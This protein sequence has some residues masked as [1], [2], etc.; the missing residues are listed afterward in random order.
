M[1]SMLPLARTFST[2]VATAG[3][4]DF[5][6]IVI[7]GGGLVGNAMAAAIGSKPSL[8][9]HKVLLLESGQ[10]KSLGAPPP[11]HSN[12]VFAVGPAA[13]RMFKEF[14]VWPRLVKYRVKEVTDLYVIDSCS[15]S[16][17]RF[18]QLSED[19]EIAYIVENDAIVSGLYDK[20]KDDCANVTVR[21]KAR[22]EKCVLPPSLGDLAT[23]K[24]ADGSEVATSLLIGADGFNSSVRAA[25]AGKYTSWEYNQ[26][27]IVATLEISPHSNNSIAWQ[28]FTPH[29]PIALLPL[30]ESL[31]SL[32]W[33]TTPE[34]GKHLKELAP[35]QFVDELNHYLHTEKQQDPFTNQTLF[36]LDKLGSILPIF[37]S[38]YYERPRLTPP[39]IVGLQTDNRAAFPLGFGHADSYVKSRGVLVGDAAHRM[40]PLAGQGVNLGWSDVRILVDKLDTAAKEGGDV[41]SLAYLADYDSEAQRHNMPVM[42]SVDWLNRL[43]RTDFGPLVFLRSLGLHTFEKLMPLKDLLIYQASK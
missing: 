39:M 14:G 3:K 15:D 41:G 5:Y 36:A 13:I 25:M 4:K 27:G 42:V 7:V 40:H 11:D 12:R 2:S 34:H 28:R 33:T 38:R 21:T 19:Q 32:V 9:S 35:D 22:V 30:T 23:V 26:V 10:P 20:V 24:L 6:D 43:Y 29:G 17:I 16:N 37:G 18:E 8:K 31:S 1:F